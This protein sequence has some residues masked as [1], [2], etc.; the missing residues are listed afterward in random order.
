MTQPMWKLLAQAR[1]LQPTF[2]PGN[3]HTPHFRDLERLK[4]I[5]TTVACC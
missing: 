3:L 5:V 2:A 4:M 1:T